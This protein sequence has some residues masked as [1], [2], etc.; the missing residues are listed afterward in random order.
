[1]RFNNSKDFLLRF[2]ANPDLDLDLDKKILAFIRIMLIVNDE[3][4]IKICA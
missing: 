2:M 1:M 4:Y 3:L